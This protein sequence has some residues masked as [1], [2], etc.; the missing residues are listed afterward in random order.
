MGTWTHPAL[1][2]SGEPAYRKN[3]VE[4]RRML[5]VRAA[6]RTSGSLSFR[7]GHSL[8]ASRLSPR[9]LHCL[10]FYATTSAR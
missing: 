6:N 5:T 4:R 1:R 2:G 7:L 10:P 9:L 3:A 8:T